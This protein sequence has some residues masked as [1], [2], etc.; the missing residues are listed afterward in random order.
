[1]G[2]LKRS[3]QPR[4]LLREEQMVADFAQKSWQERGP[5]PNPG[6]GNPGF[7]RGQ[8]FRPTSGMFRG[9][10]KE[11]YAAWHKCKSNDKGE[12]K[13]K[14]EGGSSSSSQPPPPPPRHEL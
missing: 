12:G 3:H 10:G 4:N 1:M 11:F 5:A 8:A 6:D 7:W 13:G 9:G 14:G 2:P